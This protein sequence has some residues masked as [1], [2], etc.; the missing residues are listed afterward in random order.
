M[1]G[2]RARSASASSPSRRSSSPGRPGD[3]GRSS[4]LSRVPAPRSILLRVPL[5]V[6]RRPVAPHPR[7]CAGM[8][9]IP[10]GNRGKTQMFNIASGSRHGVGYVPVVPW[11]FSLGS[12]LSSLKYREQR[13]EIT[14]SGRTR[15][16]SWLPGRARSCHTPSCSDRR[17]RRSVGGVLSVSSSQGSLSSHRDRRLADPAPPDFSPD[18]GRRGVLIPAPFVAVRDVGRSIRDCG[19]RTQSRST[20]AGDPRR[21]TAESCHN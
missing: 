9:R 7:S 17:D 14:G 15:M 11:N 19:R 1:A 8:I 21:K 12:M 5:V 20:T 18:S 4:S 6:P 10:S 3:S 13:S 16:T 2:P